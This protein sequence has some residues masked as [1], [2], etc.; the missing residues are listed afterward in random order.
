MVDLIKEFKVLR[1][2][3]GFSQKQLAKGTGVSEITWEA[4]TREPTIANFN[5]VLNKMGY[6]LK[7]EPIDQQTNASV[8][9]VV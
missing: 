3:Q 6:Q 4:H 9:Q 2:D 1:R 7:I 5:K 8:Q